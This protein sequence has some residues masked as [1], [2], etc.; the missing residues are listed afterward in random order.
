MDKDVRQKKYDYIRALAILSVVLMHL[1]AHVKAEPFGIKWWIVSA[2]MLFTSTCNGLFFL[3]SGKFNLNLKNS[4]DLIRF[5]KKR[6]VSIVIPFLVCSFICFIVEKRLLGTGNDYITS[7]ISIF[8]TTHY[9][10]AYEL[11]GLIV[12]T[13]FFAVMMDGLALK[14]KCI[15]TALVLVFQT[16]FVFIKDVGAYPG[17]E[18]PL[19]GWPLFY[20]V[21]SFADDIPDKWRKW[22][23]VL[24]AGGFIMSL[25]QMRLLPDASHGLQDLS[26]KYFFSV[27]AV[28]YI[29]LN[30]S[31]P[32]GIE[33]AALFL[34]QYS[35]YIYLFHN[36]V[37]M[38]FFS[39]RLDVYDYLINKTGTILFLLI[40]FI[41]SIGLSVVLGI[42][43]KKIISVVF[44]KIV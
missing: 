38:I 24:G 30:V 42:M 10:F 6:A 21:G 7:L 28:Y 26:P 43:V 34:S 4:N 41:A 35:Y 8:P 1:C 16:V 5:Y 13:P 31:L 25:L 29:L 12:W 2:V 18:V 27:L 15:M 14:G 20:L 40:V 19:L 39:E 32:E 37:I 44:K 33:K 3:L 11:I 36:T 17:Y 23:I 22:I 9:W